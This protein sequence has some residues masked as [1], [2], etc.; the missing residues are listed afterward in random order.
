MLTDDTTAQQ[1][2]VVDDTIPT[3]EGGD[4]LKDT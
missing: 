3:V 4:F 1:A 2:K